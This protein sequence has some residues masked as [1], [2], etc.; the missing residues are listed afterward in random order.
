VQF[1]S[2]KGYFRNGYSFPAKPLRLQ[3][4]IISD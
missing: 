4:P 3:D 1:L 2:L